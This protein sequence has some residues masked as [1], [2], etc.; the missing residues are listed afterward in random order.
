M[1]LYDP[2]LNLE[3]NVAELDAQAGETAYSEIVRALLPF[4]ELAETVVVRPSL[5]MP[6][7]AVHDFFPYAD[8]TVFPKLRTILTTVQWLQWDN[9]ARP[10]EPRPKWSVRLLDVYTGNLKEQIAAEFGDLN[11]RRSKELA[12]KSKKL[13]KK[14]KAR[15]NAAE[16]TD[17]ETRF[18]DQ[19]TLSKYAVVDMWLGAARY[20]RKEFTLLEDGYR[21]YS[22]YCD[23]YCDSYCDE[24]NEWMDI[25][26]TEAKSAG[27]LPQFEPVAM[28][29]KAPLV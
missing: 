29:H 11:P 14:R 18:Q 28:V 17:R 24:E 27:S 26:L 8:N 7:F 2:R 19:D 22:D 12:K 9:T 1:H 4:A 15:W 5:D 16:P 13:A 20:L 21:L 10:N 25:E 6:V 3:P 23:W